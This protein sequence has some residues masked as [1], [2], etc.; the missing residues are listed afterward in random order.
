VAERRARRRGIVR[1]RPTEENILGTEFTVD[2][3]GIKQLSGTPDEDVHGETHGFQ[4]KILIRDSLTGDD[5]V[6]TL[7]HE[8]MH[9]IL[10][11][12]GWT[13][14]LD[15]KHEEGVVSALESG[16]YPIIKH[17]IESGGVK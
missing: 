9:A 4:K 15:E 2:Y 8:Y 14:A 1:V 13:Y 12:S 3:V 16:L 17:W 5:L 10:H 7:L 11:V 6:S